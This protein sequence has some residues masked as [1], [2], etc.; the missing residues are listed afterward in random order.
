MNIK[1]RISNLR[2]KAHSGGLP[3]R[4]SDAKLYDIL[5]QCLTLCED[6]M[7]ECREDEL[8]EATR[9]GRPEGETKK[10]GRWALATSDVFLL[11]A[12]GVLQD[13]DSSPNY[14]RYASVMRQANKIGIAGADL[15]EWLIRNGGARRLYR[16]VADSGKQ[17]VW[18]IQLTSPI[19]LPT[20]VPVNL[21]LVSDGG[22]QFRV[23]G[24]TF[25]TRKVAA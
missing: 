1:E 19:V 15:S 13:C 14:S 22:G 18:A 8:R 10:R 16:T 11:V 5:G 17:R 20:D 2:D 3:V 24:I 9:E 12:R 23:L 6:V 21:T 7:R 4:R 25:E